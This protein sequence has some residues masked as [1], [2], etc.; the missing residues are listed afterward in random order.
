MRSPFFA[1]IAGGAT[2]PAVA[3]CLL[4][5]AWAAAGPP[6]AT[7]AEVRALWVKSA[8]LATPAAV[9]AMV[10]AARAGGFNTLLVQVRGRGDAYFSSQLEPRAAALSSQPEF[11]DP[12][13]LTLDL[14]HAAGIRVHA[15]IDVGLVSSAVQLPSSRAHVVNRH[16]EWLMVPRALARDLALIDARSQTYLDKLVRWTR[17]QDEV[18]GL[19]MSPVSEDAAAATVAVVADI[20]ARYPVDGVHLDYIRY[21]SDDF[22]YSLGSL[23]A[24]KASVLGR[25]DA[26]AAEHA[27]REVGQDLVGWAEAFPDRWREFRRDRLTALVTRI[28]DSVKARRPEVTVSAAVA[29]DAAEASRRRLQDW[30]EWI[31]Q[32]L[33]DVVCPMAYTTDP[34]AFAAQVAAARQSAGERPLWAGIGAYRLS[35]RDTVEN[36]RV[37]RDLGAAGVVLFSYDALTAHPRGFDYLVQVSRAAFS[38]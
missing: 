11:F 2:A 6:R 5:A 25:L 13:A 26:A 17:A 24:F 12:L 22:D 3:V 16:P 32:G 35:L 30:A 14:A 38:R 15:W 31:R 33:L 34:A 37:A 1:R 29:P 19:Y 27:Q 18:E 8:S 4:S 9:S 28:R 36:I 23:Q 20:A 7:T 21:P 10:K